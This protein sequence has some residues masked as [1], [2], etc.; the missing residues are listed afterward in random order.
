MFGDSHHSIYETIEKLSKTW[1]EG[2]II[3]L[4]KPA[5]THMAG[6]TIGFLRLLHLGPVLEN[7]M[8]APEY[9]SLKVDPSATAVLTTNVKAALHLLMFCNQKVSCMNRLFCHV[10]QCDK[11]LPGLV[12]AFNKFD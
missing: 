6:C 3:H 10:Q 5:E 8:A 11:W 4:F 12:H 7:M 2:Q 9:D 1:N